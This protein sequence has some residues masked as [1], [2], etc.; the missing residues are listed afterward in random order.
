MV[1]DGGITE[2][3]ATAKAVRSVT[4]PEDIT[5]HQRERVWFRLTEDTMKD[6]NGQLEKTLP[7]VFREF[8]LS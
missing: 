1:S 3:Q 7:N 5:L 8:L 4:V 2:G 6:L